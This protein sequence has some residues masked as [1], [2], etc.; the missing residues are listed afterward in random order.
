MSELLWNNLTFCVEEPIP[1]PRLEETVER[2]TDDIRLKF[3]LS[4]RGCD[5]DDDDYDPKLWIK[6]GFKAPEATPEI[7][8][9]MEEFKHRITMAS[10]A[11]IAKA[12][13]KHNLSFMS[14]KLLKTLPE[15]KEFIIVPTDKNL[16]PAILEKSTYI[17]R[18]LH[19]HLL[20]ASTY[21]RLTKTE[22]DARLE[23]AIYQLK[24]QVSANRKKLSK[25]DVKFFDRSLQEIRAGLRRLPQF[26]LLP[27][28]H[29]E[30]WA[31]RPVV[32]C[33]NSSM[34][35]PSKWLDVKLQQVVRL[36]PCYLKDSQSLL[37][38]LKH[39]GKLPPTAM[40]VTADAVSMYTN[41][42]TQHGLQTLAKWF[43]LHTQQ[44]PQGYPT[45]MVLKLL[46][47]VMTNNVFQLDDT[48]WL[49]LSGTA[50]GTN[51]ACMYATIYY[52]YLEET[53]ILPRYSHQHSVMQQLAP[54]TR[55]PPTFTESPL[56]M[57]A[58]LIDDACQIWDWAK[59]PMEMKPNFTQN[60]S[61]EMKFG[62]LEWKVEKPSKSID[63][64]DLNISI[65]E[66]G[67]IHTKTYV[68]PMNLHLYIPPASAH[69]NGVLKSLIF[70]TL[71]R[72]WMQ[73]T[74][75]SDFISAGNA[76]YGHLLNRGWSSQKLIPI[77]L[78]AG[79]ALDNKSNAQGTQEEQ[80]WETPIASSSN[81]LFI[82]WNYHPRDIGRKAIRQ[83]YE[84][85]LAP[86][87]AASK[88]SIRKVTIAYSKPKSLGN[89]LTKTQL[90]EPD[91]V[92]VSSYVEPMVST[93]NL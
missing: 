62:S 78:E 38:K 2:L 45:Q 9:A 56:L 82:H 27:K 31:T 93:A 65:Q 89:I 33:V 91:H 49:Q 58:R 67:S 16:G 39:L 12:K 76:F 53:K 55:D 7:E 28:V 21:K 61:N 83:I 30:P 18:C 92:R 4:Q 85:T 15:N 29:K 90:E 14:R 86:A 43:D 8:E 19:D 72:Y 26:R 57:H 80:L 52:S 20:D 23:G 11:N 59:L 66:D 1:R 24:L 10:Q 32:S 70:G 64:L 51:V 87:V 71:Q 34:G 6:S 5:L 36:C 42:D 17:N 40:L 60:L 47:L 79:A 22:A 54:P 50:M 88:L 41:I 69:P 35:D 68:K 73:N 46:K 25:A 81:N 84:E 44:L 75:R 74:K 63:F 13:R 37:R 3:F 77:F 48:Y